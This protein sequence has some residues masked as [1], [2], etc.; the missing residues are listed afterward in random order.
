M[1]ANSVAETTSP[2]A[3]RILTAAVL[4]LALCSST[5]TAFSP[6]ISNR[7]P[8]RSRAISPPRSFG[9]QAAAANS[10]IDEDIGRL[11]AKARD[12]LEKSKAKLASRERIANGESKTA[13][14]L[15]FFASAEQR[16]AR[17]REAV[18]KST[19]AKTGLVT[20]DGERMAAL[21][22]TEQWEARPLSDVFENEM[23]E[24][25]DVY[26]I[27]SKQLANRDLAASVGDMRK[28]LHMDDFRRIFDKRNRFIGEDN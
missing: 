24:N 13:D 18:I 4:L 11:Q 15:P 27:T 5:T 20:A 8:L 23:G 14:P 1:T 22:E 25:E 17:T 19:D 16:A 10:Q 7:N 12:L 26:S 9:I 3:K 28:T 21:S 6:G 2:C